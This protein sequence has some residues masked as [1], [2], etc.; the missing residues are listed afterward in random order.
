MINKKYGF[1]CSAGLF[2]ISVIT[3]IL[4]VTLFNHS[5]PFGQFIQLFVLLI[6]STSFIG[7]IVTSLMVILSSKTK[8]NK[9][10]T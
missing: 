7:G 6:G 5:D 2:L 4:Y 10:N 8:V 3:L 1:I 9:N